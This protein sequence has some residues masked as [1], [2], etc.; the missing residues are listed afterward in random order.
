VTEPPSQSGAEA[1]VPPRK[2]C[3]LATA[4]LALVVGLIILGALIFLGSGDD[5]SNG[6]SVAFQL[7]VTDGHLPAN[8]DD[9]ALDPYRAVLRRLDDACEQD[10]GEIAD[11]A[12]RASAE[13]AESGGS[14]TRL[15]VLQAMD[16]A[17]PEAQP[18]DCAALAETVAA[19]VS[20]G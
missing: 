17:V 12:V 15:A 11:L 19:E 1:N 2:G 16:D 6:N 7:A 5:E 18:A 8:D 10:A 20:E 13:A 3:L 9:P 14:T 4:G